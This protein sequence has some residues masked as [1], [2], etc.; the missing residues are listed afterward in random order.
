MDN[1]EITLNNNRHILQTTIDQASTLSQA[2]D[3]VE[4]DISTPLGCKSAID[5]LE[6]S[7]PKFKTT[8]QAALFHI[9]G[10]MKP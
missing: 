4:A 8:L 2:M 7:L 5:L 1:Q 9:I 6:T 10:P 3:T